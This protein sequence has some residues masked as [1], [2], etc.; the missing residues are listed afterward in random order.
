M[1]C[2]AKI[3]S[4]QKAEP[5]MLNIEKNEGEFLFDNYLNATSPGQACVLYLDD[6][7]LGGGWIAK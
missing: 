2:H 1:L 6:Q 5:G 4:T 3:R 7:L